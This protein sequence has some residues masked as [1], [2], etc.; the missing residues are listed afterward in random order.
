MSWKRVK[1]QYA[2]MEDVRKKYE[3]TGERKYVDGVMVRLI[4]ATSDLYVLKTYETEKEEM[5][6]DSIEYFEF[7]EIKNGT[8]GGMD[9][10]RRKP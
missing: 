4:R 7:T 2:R 3:F 1:Q 10:R 9:R 6:S 8:L 5:K